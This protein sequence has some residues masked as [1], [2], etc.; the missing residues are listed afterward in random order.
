VKYKEVACPRCGSL[1]IKKNGTTA[2]HKQRFKCKDCSR[3]F[4]LDYTY[5]GC[6]PELRQLIVPMTLNGSGISDICRVLQVSINTVLKTIRQQAARVDEP[7]V[8]ARITE[9][10]IDEM[11]S[12]VGKK[13]NPCWLWYGF[14]ASRQKVVCWHLGRRTDESCKRLLEKL[15]GCQVM[16]YCTDELESYQKFLPPAQ[17]WIGKEGTQRIERNNLN[18]RTHLKRLQ[19]ETICFSKADDMHYAV[20]KLYIRHLNAGQHL[21]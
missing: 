8:P 11:W 3:Q 7:V 17:H 20:T 2:N 18:F 4:I 5:Q 1:S 13:G 21:L 16:R 9:L 12:F 15:S 10:E 14:D 6:R 19:R